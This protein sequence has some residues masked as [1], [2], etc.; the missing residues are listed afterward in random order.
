VSSRRYAAVAASAGL[1][2]HHPVTA[3]NKKPAENPGRFN[4]AGCRRPRAAVGVGDGHLSTRRVVVAELLVVGAAGL[5]VLRA[6]VLGVSAVTRFD[7]RVRAA[8]NSHRE[9]PLLG[10]VVAR[11]LAELGQRGLTVT[12]V[13]VL[14]V[15]AVRRSGSWRPGLVS[16]GALG[17]LGVLGQVLK[18]E[19][20][21]LAP[22]AARVAVHA[23]G[24]SWPSGHA[25]NTVV[26]GALVLWLLPQVRP[27]LAVWARL[28]GGALYSLAIAGG[29][30][31]LVVLD[32]H[33]ASD[34]VG[35]WLL[36]GVV[37]AVVALL[38]TARDGPRRR[39][40]SGAGRVVI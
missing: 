35:G 30:V 33:W 31:A 40:G 34:V 37:L 29:G 5:V 19:V 22:R 10:R 15:L 7:V 3:A 23:G 8:A 32:Y 13:V 2:V 11:A 17:L 21:R 12:V 16:A 4:P 38:A 9:L 36:G 14:A 39:S 18:F 28:V 20:G 27:A 26:S 25:A 24:L 1:D 6:G